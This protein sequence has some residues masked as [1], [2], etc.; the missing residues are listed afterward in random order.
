MFGS[1]SEFNGIGSDRT[2]TGL[3]SIILQAIYCV[4]NYKRVMR[5]IC[6]ISFLVKPFSAV[7]S[8]NA[9][10]ILFLASIHWYARFT[11]ARGRDENQSEN[12]IRLYSTSS[13]FLF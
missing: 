9:R 4:T 2:I 11:Y 13:F 8:R 10:A 1:V 12:G 6:V 7:V 3:E 5:Y